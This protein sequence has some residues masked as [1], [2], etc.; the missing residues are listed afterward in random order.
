MQDLTDE[1][2]AQMEHEV[3]TMWA[4]MVDTYEKDWKR[5]SK[6]YGAAASLLATFGLHGA[7]LVLVAGMTKLQVDF[8]ERTGKLLEMSDLIG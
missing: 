1:A 8:A 7:A 5:I 3:N 2:K 6:E 4:D